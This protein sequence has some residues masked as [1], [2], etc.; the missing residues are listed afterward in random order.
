M[1]KQLLID[2]AGVGGLF[3]VIS[4][5][6]TESKSDRGFPLVKGILQ[7]E[8]ALN[9][10]RRVYPSEILRRE[11]KKYGQLIKERR[12]LGELDHPDS[13]IVTLANASH[14]IVEM[15]WEGKDLIGTCEILPTPNGNILKELLNAGIM[16]GISSRGMGSVQ[17]VVNEEDGQPKLIVQDDF[18]ICAWDFV[19]N[20]ST[21]GAYMKPQGK[22]HEGVLM[23]GKSNIPVNK[24][25]KINS[26]ISNII[27]DYTKSTSGK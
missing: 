14:N 23:E 3:H 11:A 2:A 27:C 18:E 24:Y 20:P 21:Q 10:N 19:S 12:A 5:I 26:I 9:Q 13:P 1:A 8:D 22:V 16:V 6:L 17:E 4:G 7:R 15:H 25:E